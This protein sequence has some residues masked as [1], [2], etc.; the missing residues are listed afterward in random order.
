MRIGIVTAA[1][2]FLPAFSRRWFRGLVWFSIAASP[3]LQKVYFDA[4]QDAV[5]KLGRFLVENFFAISRASLITTVSG[6]LPPREFKYGE[7]QDIAIDRRHS[8]Q[9]PVLRVLWMS[10]SISL[11]G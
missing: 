7:P 11:S 3:F 9:A 6:V 5:D 1:L 10:L 4:V 2:Q 8:A